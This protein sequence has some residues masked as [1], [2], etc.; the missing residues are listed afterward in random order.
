MS[1]ERQVVRIV[2]PF[3][4]YENTTNA[5]LVK[6]GT[7]I[8]VDCGAKVAGAYEALEKALNLAGI[9]V[10]DIGA[11]LVTHGHPDH[12]GLSSRVS[13]EA[14]CRVYLG[15][16]DFGKAFRFEQYV[17]NRITLVLS[18]LEGSHI[19]EELVDRAKKLKPPDY[20]RVEPPTMLSDR[21]EEAA[22]Q[23]DIGY[24]PTPGHTEGSVTYAVGDRVFTGDSVLENTVLSLVNLEEY[25][26]SLSA[27]GRMGARTLYPGH[28]RVL[29][30]PEKWIDKC[31]LKYESR[32]RQIATAVAKPVDLY[33]AST[34]LYRTGGSP[35][36]PGSPDS[37]SDYLM[38]LRLL[39]TK[40]Y[41]E[42]AIKRGLVEEQTDKEKS[43][44]Q[45][46]AVS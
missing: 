33:E 41:L 24:K 22:E 35:G 40:V 14:S 30:E 45:Y 23:F 43:V 7:P 11:V 25:L 32:L 12:L 3:A 28:G 13:K 8:L 39:Q 10:S 36:S 38:F 27:I 37:A 20:Y 2:L 1:D 4:G 34:A 18:E 42:A 44:K 31:R 19:Y 9:G 17:R 29:D 15:G 26:R 5:Y 16:P 6:G 46:R 21:L